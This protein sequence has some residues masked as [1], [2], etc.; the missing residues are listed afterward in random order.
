VARELSALGCEVINYE[1][2]AVV[3]GETE[4]VLALEDD[5][6]SASYD[7]AA[8]PLGD[9]L[10]AAWYRR[11]TEF[12]ENEY[13]QPDKAR[14]ESMAGEYRAAQ[15]SLWSQVPETTWLNSPERM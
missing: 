9:E 14:F 5:R 11:P 7:G 3:R 6:L 13:D 2:D 1:A 8:L 10:G 4:L 12:V 15:E